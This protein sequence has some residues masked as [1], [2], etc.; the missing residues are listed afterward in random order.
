MTH[1]QNSPDASIGNEDELRRPSALRRGL[2]FV[3]LAAMFSTLPA[4]WFS[5]GWRTWPVVEQFSVQLRTAGS[6]RLLPVFEEA[7]RESPNAEQLAAAFAV[8]LTTVTDKSYLSPRN[9]PRD[10]VSVSIY[11]WPNPVTRLPW[12]PRDGQRNPI[13]DQF[14]A[15]RLRLMVDTVHTLAAANR[16][17]ADAQ[18]VQWLRA[19]FITPETRMHPHLTYAQMMPGI[20]AGGRQGIIEGLAISTQLLDAIGWLDQRDALAHHER[21]ELRRWLSEYLKWLQH[22]RPGQAEAQR[23]NN[24]GTWYDVQIAALAKTLG[25]QEQLQETLA[26]AQRRATDQFLPDG[27]QPHELRRT[28]SFAYSLYNLQAWL[29][30]ERIAS[31]QQLSVWTDGPQAAWDYLQ[32]HAASWPHPDIEGSN[33]THRLAAFRKQLAAWEVGPFKSTRPQQQLAPSSE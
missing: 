29:H 14:D 10:Y 7:P 9:D 4:W 17:D 21:S 25:L 15:P 13:A 5:F 31:G 32:Q 8:P 3:A 1:E 20:A 12:L 11:W 22:S 19:W 2:R 26:R 16:S 30:L 27:Q 23:S 28:K 18:A 33:H 6:A 24:H